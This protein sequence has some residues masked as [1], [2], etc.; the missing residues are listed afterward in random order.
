MLTGLAMLTRNDGVMLIPAGAIGGLWI[1]WRKSCRI[2]WTHLIGAGL[3]VFLV[4]L[5]WLIR[6]QSELGT[7]WPGS[8][9]QSMWVTEHE[10]FYAYSKEI[11]LRS[12]LDQGLPHIAGKIAFELG[13]EKDDTVND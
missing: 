11:S 13:T 4:L 5:P 10:D 8:T 12:Y 1:G 6:N 7:L 2:R 9:T 3:G